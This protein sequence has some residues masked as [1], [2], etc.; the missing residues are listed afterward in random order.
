MPWWNAVGHVCLFACLSET[1]HMVLLAASIAVGIVLLLRRAPA[2]SFTPHATEPSRYYWCLP[3]RM[4]TATTHAYILISLVL[5]LSVCPLSIADSIAAGQSHTG[6]LT[7]AG[8]VRCW[9]YNLY[10]QASA[11]MHVE[12]FCILNGGHV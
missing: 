2:H 6:A 9:G 7:T 12:C 3:R 5:L 1:T 10:G 4:T 8:G 11:C